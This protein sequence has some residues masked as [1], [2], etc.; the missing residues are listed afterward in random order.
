MTSTSVGPTAGP[1]RPGA[2]SVRGGQG[3][4]TVPGVEV[5]V[6]AT[7]AG[8]A[9][10]AGRLARVVLGAE[11]PCA[12]ARSGRGGG[13]QVSADRGEASRRSTVPAATAMTDPPPARNGRGKEY[14]IS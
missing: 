5:R 2:G 9:V 14:A 3:S 1:S 7:V 11:T 6:V 4:G 10:A 8:D 12:H 13:D